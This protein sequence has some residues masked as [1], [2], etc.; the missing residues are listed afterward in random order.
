MLGIAA[1]PSAS[2]PMKARFHSDKLCSH[3]AD[4]ADD[5]IYVWVSSEIQQPARNLNDAKACAILRL[6]VDLWMRSK[7]LDVTIVVPDANLPV[8]HPTPYFK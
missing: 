3:T 1:G 2:R 4:A 8:L 7:L 6:I 5:H